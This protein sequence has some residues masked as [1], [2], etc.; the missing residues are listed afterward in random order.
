LFH[1]LLA[2]GVNLAGWAG[3]GGGGMMP[4]EMRFISEV[5]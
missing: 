2:A 1:R 5:Y 4:V 3:G